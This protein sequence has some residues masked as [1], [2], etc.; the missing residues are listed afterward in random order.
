MNT[1]IWILVSFGIT[2]GICVSNLF[3]PIWERWYESDNRLV[4]FA[5]KM[6][7][8]PMCLGFWVGG[9]LNCWFSP[10]SHILLDM[11]Q[12]SGTCWILY[13]MCYALS[14]GRL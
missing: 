1:L 13:T 10:T 9:A 11:F 4:W 8:C 14:R 7:L 12:S 6:L 5:G 2:N 3:T